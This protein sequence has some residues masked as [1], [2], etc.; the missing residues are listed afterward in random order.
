MFRSMEDGQRPLRLEFLLI[1]T[2]KKLYERFVE[3]VAG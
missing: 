3:S 2:R 1:S